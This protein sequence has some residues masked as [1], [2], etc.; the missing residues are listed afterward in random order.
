MRSSKQKISRKIRRGLALGLMLTTVLT[1]LTGCGK[2]Q[3]G[4]ASEAD[5]VLM[6]STYSMTEEPPA[7]V[8]GMVNCIRILQDRL[9]LISTKSVDTTVYPDDWEDGMPPA[10]A[11]PDAFY[12]VERTSDNY[13]Y[14]YSMTL[15]G[16]DVKEIFSLKR[17]DSETWVMDDSAIGGD[18]SFYLLENT[19]DEETGN[20]GYEIQIMNPDGS[21]GG[22]ISMAKALSGA[23][24]YM[25]SLCAD[26]KGN[27]AFRS[28]NNVI[29][30][31]KSGEVKCSLLSDKYVN[32]LTYDKNGNFVACIMDDQNHTM[33][34]KTID[35]SAGSFSGIVT[36]GS[37]GSYICPGSGEYDY[38]FSGTDGI[39][40][41]KGGS[42]VKIMDFTASGLSRMGTGKFL[43]PDGQ[44]IVIVYITDETLGKRATDLTFM[45]KVD[46]KELAN[47]QTV[48]Y[49]GM[50]ISD[51][52]KREA[53][54]YNKSQNKYRIAFVDYADREDPTAAFSADLLSGNVPDIIDMTYLP[55]YKF[56]NKGMLSDLY[57]YIDKDP[58][59]SRDDF[60]E[61]VL[62]AMEID[63]KLYY[64][65]SEYLVQAMVGD[66][67]KVGD[68][69]SLSMEDVAA[70]EQKTGGRLF[71]P[72]ST[73][74]SVL[75]W[76]TCGKYDDYIDQTTGKCSFDSQ[77][78][79][80]LLDYANTYPKEDPEEYTE[81][82]GLLLKGDMI[83]AN[84]GTTNFEE[85][86][87]Y[88]KLLNGNEVF[89]GKPP[90]TGGGLT[91]S[92]NECLTI[93]SKSKNADGA[94][95]FIRRFLLRDHY[96]S[97]LRTYISA[98]PVRKDCFEDAA[99]VA[100]ATETWTDSYGNKF[101]PI[102]GE[103][104]VGEASIKLS[105][106]TD[107]QV[108]EMRSLIGR[109]ARVHEPDEAIDGIINEEAGALF[110]GQKSAAQVADIIQNR[111]SNYINEN[112]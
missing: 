1:A 29:V 102:N 104:G 35:L 108:D 65:T 105:P 78:F 32:G 55:L 15:D 38:Y 37:T 60:F 96:S 4:G 66:Q 46:P 82:N 5:Q 86:V 88:E 95:D 62:Q 33:D 53:I 85:I 28:E 80:S 50:Y 19:Y 93:Y 54:K 20:P 79:I 18:G 74:T 70:I 25:S 106:L 31:D 63:G 81:E 17:P 44:N 27:L 43:V 49:G 40:G 110:A 97:M 21:D 73:S 56:V 107:A 3:T 6:N 99:R 58:E 22:R 77:Q 11:E 51:I 24:P 9:Y 91:I 2:K 10:D 41:V 57:P 100:T 23:G 76:L 112:R 30:T 52:I 71:N 72:Q 103:R 61:N 16:S 26:E 47:I 36:V 42:A 109:V 90:V 111:V 8:E 98:M 75:S 84:L 64:A 101:S 87:Y 13:I 45:K 39:M 34:F 48:T 68:V 7:G 92:P 67:S 83:F 89:T 12:S 59:L 14:G 94:W 69:S